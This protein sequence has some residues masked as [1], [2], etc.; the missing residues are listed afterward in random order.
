MYFEY[1]LGKIVSQC[2]ITGEN[3]EFVAMRI[4][5]TPRPLKSKDKLDEEEEEDPR[6]VLMRSLFVSLGS[7]T[8]SECQSWFNTAENFQD[9]DVTYTTLNHPRMASSRPTSSSRVT[10]LRPDSGIEIPPKGSLCGAS[11]PRNLSPRLTANEQSARDHEPS[12]KLFSVDLKP[13]TPRPSEDV[14]LTTS[15]IDQ[16]SKQY[17][18]AFY[19]CP[20]QENTDSESGLGDMRD[21]DV[22]SDRFSAYDEITDHLFS[23]RKEQTP[24]PQEPPKEPLVVNTLEELGA[25]LA[26]AIIK[27]CLAEISGIKESELPRYSKLFPNK[28][29]SNVTMDMFGNVCIAT[30]STRFRDVE[31]DLDAEADA[32]SEEAKLFMDDDEGEKEDQEGKEDNEE[33]IEDKEQEGSNGE[34][35]QD[36]KE[37]VMDQEGAE[38]KIDQVNNEANVSQESSEDKK[39]LESCE[40]AEDKEGSE[41]TKDQVSSEGKKDQES[42]DEESDVDSLL[43]S[44]E[45]YEERDTFFRKHKYKTYDLS[46]KKGIDQFKKFLRGTKGELYWKMWID[47]DRSRL[48][49]KDEDILV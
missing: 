13:T 49:N 3:G 47:I 21:D 46:K 35:V 10:A 42:K 48:I 44:E 4:D 45:D 43:D 32:V 7:A 17:A 41:G 12:S 1:R 27:H 31:E 8:V 26:G 24:D 18:S 37:D 29:F 28:K 19:P 38:G 2:R 6:K 16:Q 22:A 34:I 39:D 30:A 33:G 40:V 9:T 11:Y 15:D 5:Y 36:D 23:E 25:V 20:K 14:C